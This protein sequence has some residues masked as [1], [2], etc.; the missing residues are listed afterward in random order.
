MRYCAVIGSPISHSLSPAI[1]QAAYRAAGLGDIS[2]GRH[3]VNQASLGGF[4][5]SC[6]PDWLGLSVT[7]P[8]KEELL[9]FGVADPIAATLRSANTLIFGHGEPNRLY[10]TDV[11]GLVA[12]LAQLGVASLRT[13]V[14]VGAGA[15]ARSSLY[16]AGLLGVREVLVLARD[17]D[18]AQASLG[19]LAQAGGA[20]GAIKLS[21]VPFG[22]SPRLAAHWG[23]RADLLISTVPSVLD[24][25][26][27]TQ[28]TNLAETVFDLVYTHYPSALDRAAARAQLPALNGLHLL[29]HQA[30]DQLRL[31]VGVAADPAELLQVCLAEL[32]SHR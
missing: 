8:C 16:A 23:E 13:M 20:A 19:G 12:A 2:Y 18:R 32:N 1:H 27:A 29:V 3:E 4:L 10:N 24:E 26:Y 9:G 6:T 15:T 5:A 22:A 7:A 25:D 30:I 14:L 31:M 28:L 11:T 17:K 21:F